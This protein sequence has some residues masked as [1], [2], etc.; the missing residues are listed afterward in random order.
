MMKHRI[1]FALLA[2]LL[3]TAGW[4]FAAEDIAGDLSSSLVRLHIL[5][6][7][8]SAEDQSLKLKVRDRLLHEA[9]QKPERLT[10]EEIRRICRDEICQN[11]YDYPVSVE[12]GSF[13]F[14]RKTYDK[15][16]LPA[17]NYR[18]VRILIG[19]GAGEN[20]WCVMYPPLCFTGEVTD[21]LSQETLASLESAVS[22]ESYQMICHTESVTIKPSFKLYE[23]WQ[24]LK[25]CFTH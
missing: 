15:L 22:P 20:W 13:F 8:N 16:T 12:R 23:L 21:A 18:A 6:N 19:D 4:V 2:G 1:A 9:G 24:E 3:L 11:G 5:A 10:D 17:G 14:P 25:S 7:S